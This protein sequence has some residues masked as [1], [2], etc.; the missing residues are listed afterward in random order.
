MRGRT[1]TYG[2]AVAIQIA[3][4]DAVESITEARGIASD[5][6]SRHLIDT[7]SH[8]RAL[9]MDPDLDTI[10]FDDREEDDQIVL[11]YTLKV[12]QRRNIFRRIAWAVG[13]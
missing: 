4:P 9:G 1:R 5:R 11:S 8:I 3:G 13:L 12:R 2:Q 10:V 6:L 7:M